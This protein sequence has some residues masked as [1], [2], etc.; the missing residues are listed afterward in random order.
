MPSKTG[1]VKLAGN[2]PRNTAGE[3]PMGSSPTSSNQS[4][5]GDRN[6]PLMPAASFALF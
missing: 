2:T 3:N 4:L 1:N 5:P 6:L